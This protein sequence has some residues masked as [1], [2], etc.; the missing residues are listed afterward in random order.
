MSLANRFS[1]FLLG[2]LGVVLAGFSVALYVATR[3]HLDR[4]VDERLRSALGLLAA[5]A[6]VHPDGVE[7]EPQER[8]LP[9]GQEPGPD[10]L[11]W[12]AFDDLG[13]RVDHS[14]NLDE[15]D[16]TPSWAPAPGSP[17]LPSALEDRHGRLWRV[18]QLRVLPS[19]APD[20]GSRAAKDLLARSE[21]APEFPPGAELPEGFHRELVL[22]AFAPLG[23]VE[24]PLASLRWALIGLGLGTWGLAALACRRL[25]RRALAPLARMAESARGLD[26]SD[27]GWSLEV[28]GTG[29]ELDRLGRAFNDL[30]GR[31]HFAYER[32]RRF[33]GDASH[34]LRTPLT[35]LIGQ[36]EVAL[37]HDRP[38]EEYRRVLRSALGRSIQLGRIVEALLFLARAE[39]E[40]LPPG[41]VPL[42]LGRWVDDHLADRAANDRSVEVL[43][44]SPDGEGP[45]IRA[46]A[47]LLG[48]LL[49]NLLDNAA[50]YG[51]PGASI[52]VETS[53][54]GEG[55]ILAVED[56]GP[57][58]AAEDLPRI[59]EP[60]YRSTRARIE[61]KPGVGLGL[62][63]VQRIAHAFG[64]TVAAVARPDGGSRFEVRFPLAEESGSILPEPAFTVAQAPQ[65]VPRA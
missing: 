14:H 64:G 42:D 32:Q 25:S 44:R 9:L 15:S 16:L 40:A 36:I 29:D 22:T 23:P 12:M 62:A 8:L 6:E 55:A 39:G 1:A 33:G 41:S 21:L 4:Q 45:R 30:L 57:G 35:V 19:A 26:A 27:P 20:S 2:I 46:H 59:F 28:P 13:R 18:A 34:Q 17:D 37:R 61:G 51:P 54:D 5:A 3:M 38:P 53:H 58:I 10:R 11:R 49:D 50:K 31:L 47:P 60:F 63:V 24:A 52:V 56:A 43:R 7:W 65:V 48:Q